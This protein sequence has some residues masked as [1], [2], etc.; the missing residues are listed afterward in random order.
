MAYE[1]DPLMQEWSRQQLGYAPVGDAPGG[2]A[3]LDAPVPGEARAVYESIRGGPG[4]PVSPIG[5][6]RLSYVSPGSAGPGQGPPGAPGAPGAP[7]GPPDFAPPPAHM[8]EP[9]SP[10]E[11][12]WGSLD[13]DQREA[14]EQAQQPRRPVGGGYA[15]PPALPKL[16]AGGFMYP[17]DLD[18][19][20][21]DIE[22]A[23]L[24][25]EITDAEAANLLKDL[26]QKHAAWQRSTPGMQVELGRMGADAQMEQGGIAASGLERRAEFEAQLGEQYGRLQE[27]LRARQAEEDERE[28]A[29][30]VA[31]QQQQQRYD[32]AVTEMR[33]FRIDPD[34]YMSKQGDWGRFGTM[35]S[36]MLG[37]L[38]QAALKLPTNQAADMLM[39]RIDQDIA[40]QKEELAA[41]K[42]FAAGQQN[43]LGMMRQRFDDERTAESAARK[44]I[45]DE[46][47]FEVTK[48]GQQLK[49][50][51]QLQMRDAMLTGLQSEAALQEQQ[52]AIGAQQLADAETMRRQQAAAWAA[53]QRA[54]AGAGMTPVKGQF[55]DRAVIIDGKHIGV[56]PTKE[57]AQAIMEAA[58]G[59]NAINKQ[60]DGLQNLARSMGTGDKLAGKLGLSEKTAAAQSLS[61]SMLTTINRDFAK[62]GA[63]SGGDLELLRQ[64]VPDPSQLTQFDADTM[65]RLES[66]R[67]DVNR[68]L[69]SEM[70]S[71][72]IQ[73]IK[74]I[75]YDEKGQEVWALDRGGGQ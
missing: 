24:R 19:A 5:Q 10:E 47:S 42:D 11:R 70:Q 46:L 44:F 38:A 54:Q 55:G 69:E 64:Q 51:D 48:M 58:R 61:S 67:T 28:E 39:A 9:M 17:R 15:P 16:F 66:L 49:S 1:D 75:G 45:L 14:I 52:M 41:K 60:I 73:P 21:S 32:D 33:D 2:Y 68:M 13:P 56:A 57:Q 25:G 18:T 30:R 71:T 65:A 74:P 63:L 34:R 26:P 40:A 31:A 7:D 23:R 35:I 62:L 6:R 3:P 72:H 12:L 59:R 8:V 22:T 50:E 36:L 4:A 29:R 20:R 37:G 53:Q 43:V 27:D